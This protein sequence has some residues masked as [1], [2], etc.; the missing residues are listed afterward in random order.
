MQG[1]CKEASS[2]PFALSS[3]LSQSFSN[4]KSSH[5]RSSDYHL[6]L[7]PNIPTTRNIIL[8]RA[9]ESSPYIPITYIM[10]NNVTLFVT[11]ICCVIN[12]FV[13]FLCFCVKKDTEK[14]DRKFSVKCLMHIISGTFLVCLF[15]LNY[16]AIYGCYLRFLHSVRDRNI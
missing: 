11:K 13:L 1:S 8:F 12:N 6:L 5:L 14:E 9:S 3:L 2:D 10:C 16:N 7:H 4:V 15:C